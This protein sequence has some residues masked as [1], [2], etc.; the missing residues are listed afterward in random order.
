MKLLGWSHYIFGERR[1]WRRNRRR[2][3]ERPRSGTFLKL[4][5]N[6]ISWRG[7]RVVEI[8]FYCCAGLFCRF[9]QCVPGKAIPA[10]FPQTQ[11]KG[12]LSRVAG[13]L[14]VEVPT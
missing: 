8:L 6:L 12:I 2:G 1:E 9:P 13:Q 4:G 11:G 5:K 10:K 3:G 7:F 14:V